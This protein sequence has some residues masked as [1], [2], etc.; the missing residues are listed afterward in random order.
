MSLRR[1]TMGKVVTHEIC[2]G[3]EYLIVFVLVGL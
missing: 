3:F 1:Q 2:N